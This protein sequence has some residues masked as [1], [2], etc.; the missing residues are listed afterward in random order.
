MS[1]PETVIICVAMICTT[2]LTMVYLWA[3]RTVRRINIT[4]T[5]AYDQG[6]NDE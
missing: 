1:W 3:N 5:A 4:R 6:A 2:S